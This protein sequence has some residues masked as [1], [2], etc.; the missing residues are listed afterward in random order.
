VIFDI[1]IYLFLV[2]EFVGFYCCHLVCF[3]GSW[4]TQFLCWGLNL[5]LG[6]AEQAPTSK[7]RPRH[8][9]SMC[10]FGLFE[11]FK[12]MLKSHFEGI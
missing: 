4:C 8:S 7:L 6:R 12:T 2:F 3:V 5:G 1:F 10:E 11:K 9:L